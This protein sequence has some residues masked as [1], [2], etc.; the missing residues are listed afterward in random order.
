MGAPGH[1]GY[2]ANETIINPSTAPNLK[3]HWKRKG[4]WDGNEHASKVNGT[5]IWTT[6]L[7][8]TP[9]KCFP[10][11][12]GVAGTATITSAVI[13]GTTTSVLLVAGANSMFYALNAVNG[14]I[15]WQM[16]LSTSTD[17]YIWGSPVVYNGSVYIGTSSYGDCPLVAG[18]LFQM[19][20]TTGAI[21]H[22][23]D[24]VPQ[25]CLG[26][27]IWGTPTIDTATGELYLVT[28]NKGQCST[29]EPYT[30]AIIELRAS[31][32]SVTGSWQVP[33][34]QLK[35]DSD[36]GNTPTL[37]QARIGGTLQNLVGASNK[38]GKYYAF[39]R[40]NV[41]SGPI[42]TAQIGI[43]GSCPQCGYG[44]I[45]ASAWDGTNLYVAGGKTTINGISCTGSLRALDPATGNFIWQTC[46][47]QGPVLGAV[48][49]IPGIAV[50]T[51]GNTVSLIATDSG[52]V[53]TSLLDTT[54]FSRYF[55]S[56]TISNG[57]LYAGN[58]N[59]K[60]FAYGL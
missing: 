23:F 40:G 12:A 31:D 52:Q 55:A 46:L 13:N 45:S 54:T 36:F 14:S 51:Q 20:I 11:Q 35:G 18:Q 57:M 5:A 53:I 56:V 33:A 49:V 4:S 60:L 10:P 37:F 15:I 1:G 8:I 29:S 34:A 50:V 24:V 3:L 28:G 26:G 25:G 19:D 47:T 39:M 16:Q 58:M 41:S 38:N 17:E 6:N 27:G 44:S 48:T 42:W 7:G 43:T 2:N 59:G 9:G 21:Q 30:F 22:T 32:L